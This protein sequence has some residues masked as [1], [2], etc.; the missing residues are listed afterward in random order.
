MGGI[1]VITRSACLLR[2]RRVWVTLCVTQCT[3]S[4][5][6]SCKGAPPAGFGDA[7]SRDCGTV[8]LKFEPRQPPFL[9]G[10]AAGCQG[11]GLR[12]R[13]RPLCGVRLRRFNNGA[14]RG[15]VE[16]KFEPHLTAISPGQRLPRGD[17]GR[18]GIRTHG[19][20]YSTLDFES[21]ALDRTQPPFRGGRER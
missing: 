10:S 17:G 9:P 19:A 11:V 2:L 12:P 15:A 8:E 20:F 21:S 16:L 18:G 1:A 13:P 5:T 7:P 3:R 4:A 14:S 6:S